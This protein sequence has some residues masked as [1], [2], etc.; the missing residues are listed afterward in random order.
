MK[1]IQLKNFKIIKN[2]YGDII[3]FLSFKRKTGEVY[4]SEVLKNKKK[5]WNLHKKYTCLLIVLVGRVRFSICKNNNKDDK[6][7]QLTLSRDSKKILVIPPNTWFSFQSLS[8]SK[9]LIANFINGKHKKKET[10]KKPIQ[11]YKHPLI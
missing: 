11:I 7:T 10:L 1:K 3:K 5:G 9:S 8:K 4:F 2:R 6:I